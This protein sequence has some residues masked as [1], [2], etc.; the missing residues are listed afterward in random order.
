MIFQSRWKFFTFVVAPCVPSIT[1][2]FTLRVIPSSVFIRFCCHLFLCVA[3]VSLIIP[4]CCHTF[5]SASSH[6]MVQSTGAF[7]PPSL[8]ID[9]HACWM[10]FHI[11][12]CHAL[13]SKS[14]SYILPHLSDFKHVLWPTGVDVRRLDNGQFWRICRLIFFIFVWHCCANILVRLAYVMIQNHPPDIPS[15][16]WRALHSQRITRLLHQAPQVVIF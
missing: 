10:T 16:F 15:A 5:S 3:I 1:P 4:L 14:F 6:W 11:V 2:R 9:P 8:F 7:Y 13:S 12:F